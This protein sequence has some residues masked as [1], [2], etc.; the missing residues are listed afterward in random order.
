MTLTFYLLQGQI[1]CMQNSIWQNFSRQPLKS[2]MYTVC[3]LWK[4]LPNFWQRQ[5]VLQI[6]PVND[7]ENLISG[8][9]RL[10]RCLTSSVTWMPEPEVM[11][12]GSLSVFHC[13]RN[14]TEIQTA[15]CV[16]HTTNNTCGDACTCLI[17]CNY[18]CFASRVSTDQNSLSC[19]TIKHVVYIR[20]I[21]D[22]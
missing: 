4:L 8:E 19:I 22:L 5:Y 2:T 20:P 11:P 15:S 17:H 12:S 10:R 6:F 13:P 18:I 9:R 16:R 7:V 14:W 3:H 1:C 21:A